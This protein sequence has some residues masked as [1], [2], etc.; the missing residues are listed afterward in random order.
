MP[1]MLQQLREGSY[2]AFSQIYYIYVDALY[3]FVLART[4]SKTIAQDVVQDTFFSL[5]NSRRNIDEQGNVQAYLFMIARH[6]MVDMFRRQ[7]IQVDYDGY[8][9]LHPPA[10]SLATPEEYVNFEECKYNISHVKSLLSPREREI[11]ELSREHG[12]T[13][14]QISEKL[15]ISQQT[16]KN[17]VSS[18]LKT[19]RS[20]LSRVIVLMILLISY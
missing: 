18:G 15:G 10:S 17:Y 8:M 7:V 6:K 19:M 5:W 20:K 12:L 4:K 2:R 11:Y 3:S 1:E 13:V 9:E 14:R 16:V